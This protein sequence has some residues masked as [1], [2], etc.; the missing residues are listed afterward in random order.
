MK[1]LNSL[2]ITSS[3]DKLFNTAIKTGEWWEV[4]VVPYYVLKDGGECITIVS[5][6]GGE[7]PFDPNNQSTVELSAETARFQ[8]DS[9]AMY[10]MS[11]S[12][13]LNEVKAKNFDLVFI[14]DEYGAMCDFV[15]NK[16]L[17]QILEDFN[18]QNKPIGLV[19]HGVA[20]L[21]SL[22]TDDGEPFVKGRKL[23][24]FSNR[25]EDAMQLNEKPLFSLE[26]KLISL[27]ALYSKGTDFDSYVVADENIITGQNSSS[28]GEAAKQLLT[29]AHRKK[30]LRDLKEMSK[31]IQ[32]NILND[33][34]IY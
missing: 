17:K 18:R 27:G 21:I 5:P 3:S 4:L 29:L 26:S 15:D 11:H 34:R 32:G 23:T 10:H 25:E 31:S 8:Q 22:T 6:K 1:S 14:A 2:I 19:G 20:A 28:S 7:I 16:K 30:K 12:L 24:C 33:Q 13:P 9:Q